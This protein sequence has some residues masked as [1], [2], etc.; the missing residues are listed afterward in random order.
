[1]RL[2][3]CFLVLHAACAFRPPPRAVKSTRPAVARHA[4][5]SQQ[6]ANKVID[7]AKKAIARDPD[8]KEALGSLEKVENVLGAGAPAAGSVAV[9]FAASFRRQGN[10]FSLMS[11]EKVQ[12]N[13]GT[14]VCQVKARADG[15]KLTTC[16]IQGSGGWGRTLNVRV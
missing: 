2:D 10:I 8:V 9:S 15:G 6:D 13:R 7:L 5:C 12:A 4:T 16:S 11:G 1:M 3:L 14:N